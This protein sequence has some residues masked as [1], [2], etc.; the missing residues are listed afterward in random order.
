LPRRIVRE[1]VQAV[2]LARAGARGDVEPL[3]GPEHVLAAR[4]AGVDEDAGVEPDLGDGIEGVDTVPPTSGRLAE[5]RPPDAVV[6]ARRGLESDEIAVEEDRPVRRLED[7]S[8]RRRA[9]ST[10]RPVSPLTAKR[11]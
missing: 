10:G 6:V 5:R 11:R 3:P 7:P 1:A 4:L 8:S 2:I 9:A